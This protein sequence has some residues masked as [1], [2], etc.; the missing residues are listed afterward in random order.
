MTKQSYVVVV[1]SGRGGA[2]SQAQVTKEMA[3]DCQSWLRCIGL[4]RGCGQ[5]SVKWSRH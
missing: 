5:R 3:K 2:L 4:R 1:Q